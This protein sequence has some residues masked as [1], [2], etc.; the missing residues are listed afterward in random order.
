MKHEDYTVGWICPLP[1][2]LAAATAMLDEEHDTLPSPETDKN[3]YSLGRIGDHS[4][5]IACLPSGDT[6]T[7]SATRVA[8]QMLFTFA[9]LRFGLIVGIGGGVPSEEHDIRLGDVVVSKPTGKFPGVIQYD[10]GKTIQKGKFVRTG[11]LNKPPEVLL[12]A[13]A[14][15]QA[16]HE[17]G[18]HKLAEYLLEMIR[19]HPEMATRFARPDTECDSLYDSKYDHPKGRATCSQCDAGKLISRTSR[20][21]G[22]PVIHYGLIASGDQVMQH[23]A[24]RDRLRQELDVSCFEMEAAGLMDSFPC[25]VIRGICDY[26]DSH[27]NKDWQRYAAVTAAAY[28]KELLSFIT[29]NQVV[30]T[31]T[32]AEVT[33]AEMSA[34]AGK[35]GFK[36]QEVKGEEADACL[37]ALFLTDPLDD[38]EKITSVKGSRV[39]GTC[40][41][42]KNNKLY[43]SWLH[44]HSRL[45]CLSGGPGKG[46]TM[47]S[48]FLAEELERR[49]KESQGALFVQYFCDNRDEK[50]NTAVA[51]LRG[52][53]WQLLKRRPELSIHILPSF[54]DRD[55]SQLISSFNSLWRIFETMV[56]DPVL[57]TAYCVL[58]GL[59]E[60]DAVSLE[61]LLKRFKALFSTKVNESPICYLNLITVSRDLPDFIPEIFSTFPCIR[62]DSDADNEIDHDIHRFIE[63]RVNELS[64][65]RQYPDPLRV[66]VKKVLQDR[67]KGTFLWIGIVA[68]ELRKYKATETEKALDLFPAGLEGLYARLLLQIDVDRRETAAKILRWVVMAVR[69]LTLSEL[70]EAIEITVEPSAYFSRDDVTRDQVTLCG[71]ILTIKEDEIGLIHQSAKDY[72]LRQTPDS[73]LELEFFRIKEAT[74]NLEVAQKCF[75]YLQ[76]GALAGDE[77]D[78]NRGHHSVNT[79]YSKAFPLLSYAALHWPEHARSL[80]SSEDLF[81][82]SLPFYKKKSTIRESWL[83]IYWTAVMKYGSPPDSF[84]LLHLASHFGIMP[85]IENLL[86]GRKIGTKKRKHNINLNQKDSTGQTALHWA[87]R[88]GHEAVV[89]LLLA[90][91]ADVNAQDQWGWTALLRAAE[92]G[93]EAV[94]RLL[95]AYKADVNAQDQ[96]GWTALLEAAEGGHEAVVR[97]LKVK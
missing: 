20:T 63:V 81:E 9:R 11:S 5:V 51:I 66:H 80:A 67:A 82:L 42:I 26:A 30:G 36:S 88:S 74:A 44:S 71:Y 96:W 97:L 68:N 40:E 15:L 33:A 28:A 84:S 72:L 64:G 23:G 92:G 57:G 93:H 62:L 94:V 87:A 32:A 22:D 85:L 46:K 83:K 34:A 91:K 73:D 60:C 86:S 4:V 49:V 47:L 17:M 18:S 45:L 79:L 65:Y 12:T 43:N 8:S 41:W 3:S 19:K 70:S 90:Y 21:H 89:R 78:R 95:L 75:N 13:V 76:N 55:R 29:R 24:T 54:K 50:R 58:D 61:V 25:L 37:S 52:L 77:V 53:I 56:R 31:Q 6:G 2:E 35:R 38:R 27:K 14:K 39:D 16:R 59:D 1:I 10:F 69:P 7:I 48:I